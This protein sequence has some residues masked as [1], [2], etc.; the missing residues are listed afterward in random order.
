MDEN[1]GGKSLGAKDKFT[2]SCRFGI[3]HPSWK[4]EPTNSRGG[5]YP[6]QDGTGSVLVTEQTDSVSII[7]FFVN[8]SVG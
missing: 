8:H 6:P 7:K 5:I 4:F 1:M 3:H 2:F